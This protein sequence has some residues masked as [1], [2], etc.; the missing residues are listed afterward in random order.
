MAWRTR[1]DYRVYTLTLSVKRVSGGVDKHEIVAQSDQTSWLTFQFGLFGG[2]HLPLLS[3]RCHP[4][5]L[6]SSDK[7]RNSTRDG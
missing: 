6:A 3:R 5:T 2:E 1:A 4:N 7:T